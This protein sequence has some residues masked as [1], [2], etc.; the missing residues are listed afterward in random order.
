MIYIP[1]DNTDPYV[2][3]AFEEYILRNCR[4][5]DYFLLWQNRPSVILGRH[6]NLF[7]EVY[8][9]EARKRNVDIV[10]RESGGGAVYHDTGNLNFTFITDAD[11]RRNQSMARY[12]GKMAD[13][14]IALGIPAE[15]SGRNDIEVKGRKISGNAQSITGKRLMHHGTLLFSADTEAAQAVLRPDPE[16]FRSRSV[17]S[18]RS[19]IGNIREFLPD[20]IRDWTVIDLKKYLIDYFQCERGELDI[21]QLRQ[22]NIL[23][24]TKYRS[25]NWLYEES[26][27]FDCT[28]S[29]H[30]KAG[31]LTVNIK[32]KE[33]TIDDIRFRGDFLSQKSVEDVES[34][35][36]GT[37][38]T[39]H[40]TENLLQNLNLSVYFGNLSL[41]D[42]LNCIYS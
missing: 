24:E 5:G 36:K 25:E 19:R 12:A 38:Y 23:A 30:R 34:L 7:E 33:Q 16:K 18:V 31:R 27:E 9:E 1:F 37:S 13:A 15:V 3:L 11:V 39:R 8:V 17:S 2:N 42:I 40:V 4:D 32:I 10:R 28:H 14:L 21:D 35:L 41:N 29:I 26:R 20:A 22:I 6:Q